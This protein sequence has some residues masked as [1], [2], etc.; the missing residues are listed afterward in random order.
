MALPSMQSVAPLRSTLVAEDPDMR[1][2]VEAFVGGLGARAAEFAAAHNALDWERL[3]VLAHQ[4][5]GA[6]GSY[7]YPTLSSLAATMERAFRDRAAP[8]FAHWMN[9]LHEFIAAALAG[10]RPHSTAP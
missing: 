7:G 5:K 1:D 10:L 3:S 9:Q 6:G 2:I 4:L 8:N